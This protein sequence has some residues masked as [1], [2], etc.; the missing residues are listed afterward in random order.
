M[1]GHPAGL[2]ASQPLTYYGIEV[3]RGLHGAAPDQARLLP[4][5]GSAAAAVLGGWL[6]ELRVG[7]RLEPR[8]PDDA[9]QLRRL[10]D[11]LA[12]LLEMRHPRRHD[13]YEFHIS[14]GYLLRYLTDDQRAALDRVLTSRFPDL[15]GEWEMEGVEFC[16]F[17]N[18]LGYDTVIDLRNEIAKYKLRGDD[19]SSRC[20]HVHVSP[21]TASLPF[22]IRCWTLG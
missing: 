17:E 15:P 3:L 10:R 18:I 22:P 7:I 1:Y 16:I 13:G 14:I 5:T 11:R 21:P 2:E 9:R 20:L 6:C 8:R 19:T 12:G 4:P